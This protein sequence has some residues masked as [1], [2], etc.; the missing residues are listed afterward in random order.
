MRESSRSEPKTP[1]GRSIDRMVHY[2][3]LVWLL[4]AIAIPI[5]Y[6]VG[7]HL[8]GDNYFGQGLENSIYWHVAICVHAASF[9]GFVLAPCMKA[10]SDTRQGWQMVLGFVAFL[11][12]EFLSYV[13][14]TSQFP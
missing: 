10:Q 5:C 6:G 7:T 13:F 14:C 1:S 11:V 9:L 8:S 3:R 2:D 12:D 4:S